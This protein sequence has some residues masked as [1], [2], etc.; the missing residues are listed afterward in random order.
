MAELRLSVAYAG[1]QLSLALPESASLG[2]QRL[3]GE[4]TGRVGEE[5]VQIE[6]G[7]ERERKEIER[8]KERRE[9]WRWKENGRSKQIKAIVKQQ[10]RKMG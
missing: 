10:K 9:T 1:R 3:E 5:R 6:R 2:Q 7:R 4:R 8:E